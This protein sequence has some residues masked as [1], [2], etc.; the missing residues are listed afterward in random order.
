LLVCVTPWA[1]IIWMSI[2]ICD[3][4]INIVNECYKHIWMKMRNNPFMFNKWCEERVKIFPM[5]D[6]KS[7]KL[8]VFILI[9]NSNIKIFKKPKLVSS[10]ISQNIHLIYLYDLTSIIKVSYAN[11]KC[12]L[13]L[14]PILIVLLIIHIVPRKYHYIYN[15]Y[16]Y[17]WIY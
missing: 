4:P 9:I 3:T 14:I 5:Q 10:K 6:F 7:Y 15:I 11:W 13:T 12:R 17:I 8:G 2:L 1:L 16:I